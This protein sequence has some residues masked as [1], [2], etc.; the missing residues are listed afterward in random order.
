MFH[1]AFV[2]K[3]KHAQSEEMVLAP[4]LYN[5]YLHDLCELMIHLFPGSEP[6][7]RNLLQGEAQRTPC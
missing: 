1:F 2:Q 3:A 6:K 4:N 7:R 5:S